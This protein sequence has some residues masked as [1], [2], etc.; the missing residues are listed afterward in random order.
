VCWT[1][2]WRPNGAHEV[3]LERR[4]LELRRGKRTRFGKTAQWQ[5]AITPQYLGL[6]VRSLV[7]RIERLEEVYSPPEVKVVLASGPEN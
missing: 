4:L 3:E 7:V 1:T 5:A 6:V 2:G